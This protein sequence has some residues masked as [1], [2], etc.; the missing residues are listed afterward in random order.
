M[1]RFRTYLLGEEK[2]PLTVEKYIRD[3]RRFLGWLGKREL[4]KAE[5]LAYKA[6]LLERYAVA[7]ANWDVNK[8][9][10]FDANDAQLIYNM[11]SNVYQA[12]GEARGEA[13]KEKF[14]LADANHDFVLDTK[15]AVVIINKIL[16]SN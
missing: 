5:V 7:A 12:F 11:Y 13:T 8:S 3:V 6:E 16:G 15:D 4:C 10:R 9:G 2:G 14:M 1:E